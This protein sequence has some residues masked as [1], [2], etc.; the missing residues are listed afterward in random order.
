[1]DRH[2]FFADV[3]LKDTG[4]TELLPAA[5]MTTF[6]EVHQLSETTTSFFGETIST[7][8]IF[9]PVRDSVAEGLSYICDAVDRV[10]T[11]APLERAACDLCPVLRQD[12]SRLSVKQINNDAVII[13]P[14]YEVLPKLEQAFSNFTGVLKT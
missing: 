7:N 12:G 4:M 8:R 13:K 2:P 9:E 1:M 5:N 3:M 11:A 6:D 10:A 14:F